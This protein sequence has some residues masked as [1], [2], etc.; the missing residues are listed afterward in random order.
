MLIERF[1][2][3]IHCAF[4][5]LISVSIC[6]YKIYTKGLFKHSYRLVGE[7]LNYHAMKNNFAFLENLIIDEIKIKDRIA[8]LIGF[9]WDSKFLYHHFL[10]LNLENNKPAVPLCY[11]LQELQFTFITHS[12]IRHHISLTQRFYFGRMK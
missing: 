4:F 6:H 2:N 11:Q 9:I 1:T 3:N 7:N 8:V 10:I 12:H 5:F